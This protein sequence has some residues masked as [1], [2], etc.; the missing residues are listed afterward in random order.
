MASDGYEITSVDCKLMYALAGNF[1]CKKRITFPGNPF[2]TIE[3][4]LVPG[5]QIKSDIKNP[6]AI[7]SDIK[8]HF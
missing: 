5:C 8:N 7:G 1:N 3:I 6:I 2:T 4:I